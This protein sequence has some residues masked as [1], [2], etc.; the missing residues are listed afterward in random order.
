MPRSVA[1][2]VLE[3]VLLEGAYSHIALD[4]ALDQSDLSGKDRGLATELVYGTLTWQRALDNILDDVV[5][6]GIRRLDEPVLIALR[7]GAYQLVFL[8]RIPEHAAVDE[9]VRV[10]KR[11]DFGRAA[12]LVNA[13]MRQVAERADDATWWRDDERQSRPAQYLADRWSLPTWMANRLIQMHGLERAEV[14][15]EAYCQRPDIFLRLPVGSDVDP[16]DGA[17][18]VDGVPGAYRAEELDGAV[19][20]GLEDGRWYVQDLGSQLV[21]WFGCPEAGARVL[22]AC[23]GLGGK[24]MHLA[25][26][27]GPDGRVDA[28]DPVETKIEM[29]KAAAERVDATNIIQA[30]IGELQAFD[31]EDGYD[32]VLVD[33]PCTALGVMRR[34]PE[35]RWTRKEHHISRLATKQRDLLDAAAELVRPGGVLEYSVCTFTVEEGPKQVRQFLERHAEFEVADL[36]QREPCTSVGWADYLDETGSLVLDPAAHGTD[37]FFA[38]RLRRRSGS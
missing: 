16:P 22:D 4:A 18:A 29:L 7:V 1:Q 35:T 30:R 15:A 27:V 8:D 33:A 28:L 23:A 26:M 37:G 2:R 9:T 34:H 12:G 6:G 36:P 32:L 25:D 20:A 14:V 5:D 3:R 21:G 38:A 31:P 11:G 24:T 19:R 17:T 10:V 13:V